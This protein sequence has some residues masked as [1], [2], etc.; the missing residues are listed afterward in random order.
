MIKLFQQGVSIDIIHGTFKKY[1]RETIDDFLT[2]K[3]E[4]VFESELQY[5]L[6]E[7][8]FIIE[9]P[10]YT[11]SQKSNLTYENQ[12]TKSIT[13]Y[14]ISTLIKIKRLKLTTV[15]TGYTRQEPLDKD[16]FLRE[17]DDKS[18]IKIKYTS[19]TGPNTEILLANESYGEGIFIDLDKGKLKNWY[20][21][22]IKESEFLKVELRLLKKEFR[23]Q[24][25]YKKINFQVSIIW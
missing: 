24:K 1:E 3:D 6:K 5:R 14:G 11:E 23:S 16:L 18:P 12:D 8:K 7:Y 21:R 9:N 17:G 13:E 4:D 15:Q 20:D 2:K 10:N 19:G 25:L 22:N